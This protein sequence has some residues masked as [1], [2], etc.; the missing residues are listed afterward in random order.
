MKLPVEVEYVRPRIFDYSLQYTQPYICMEYYSYRTLHELFLY[1][2]LSKEQWAKIFSRI[3]FVLED[4]SHYRVTA[5]N[6]ADSL[7]SMYLEKTLS[8]GSFY[9]KVFKFND[10]F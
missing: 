5:E 9:Y 6:L 4:F 10:T 7:R 3:K 8:S 2:D 1:G